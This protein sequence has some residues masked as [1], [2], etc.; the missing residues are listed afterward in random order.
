MLR[1][2]AMPSRK[3][4]GIASTDA[5]RGSMGSR[6]EISMAKYA[7]SIMNPAWARFTI[8]MTP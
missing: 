6:W 4:K 8:F 5:T 3:K 1:W 2:V 7:P